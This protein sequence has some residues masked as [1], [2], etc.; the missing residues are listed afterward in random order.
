MATL[1]KHRNKWQSIVRVQGHPTLCKSFVSRTDAKRWAT[2]AE[3]K[4]RREDAGV[5]KMH[6]PKF[7][8]LARKYI[9]EVSI[10]KRCHRDERYTILGLLKE[11]WSSYPINKIRR[12]TISKYKDVLGKRVSGATVNRR[13]D[14]ISTMFTT[15]KKEWGYP[16][17]NP[18]LAIK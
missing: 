1:R 3:I 14:V 7:E 6:F 13:L 2:E 12:T 5:A 11:A 4:I 8:D 10:L 18:V 9:E 17:E 15:F 16:V